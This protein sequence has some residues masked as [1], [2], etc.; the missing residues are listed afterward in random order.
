MIALDKLIK[1]IEETLAQ[2]KAT[3]ILTLN[4]TGKSNMADAMIVCTGTSARHARTLANVLLSTLKA[5]KVVPLG[6]EGLDSQWILIDLNTLIVHI[7]LPKARE[8]YRLERLWMDDE[9]M[10]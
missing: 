3:D 4:L 7:T 9:S 1:I 8:Y 10:P 6:I 5:Q 2:F